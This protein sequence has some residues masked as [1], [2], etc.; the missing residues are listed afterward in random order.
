MNR[1]GNRFFSSFFFRIDN[2]DLIFTDFIGNVIAGRDLR[3]RCTP[4]IFFVQVLPLIGPVIFCAKL[5]SF[6]NPTVSQQTD[7][8]E[9]RTAGGRIFL[10]SSVRPYSPVFLTAAC[11]IV[12]PYFFYCKCLVTFFLLVKG[13][14]TTVLSP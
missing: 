4:A 10:I 7:L 13:V 8:D 1:K 11:I 3:F 5:D 6:I 14:G 9:I 2:C 12:F